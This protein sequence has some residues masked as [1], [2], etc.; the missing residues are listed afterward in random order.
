MLLQ[1]CILSLII[2]VLVALTHSPASHEDRGGA[3]VSLAV[4]TFIISFLVIYFGVPYLIPAIASHVGGGQVI[5]LGEPD[6]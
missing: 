3:A 5:E 2:A 6:F 4:K 1:A